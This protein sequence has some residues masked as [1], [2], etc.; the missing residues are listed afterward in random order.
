MFL[1]SIRHLALNQDF[2]KTL[3]ILAQSLTH[4]SPQILATKTYRT[5]DQA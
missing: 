5:L 1:L 3:K 2:H 4:N